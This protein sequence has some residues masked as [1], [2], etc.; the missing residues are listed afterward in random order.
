MTATWIFKTDT[1]GERIDLLI[2]AAG[3][4]FSKPRTRV[5]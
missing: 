3:L 1:P 4:V 5:I 2:D